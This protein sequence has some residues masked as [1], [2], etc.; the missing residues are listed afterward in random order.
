MASKAKKEVAKPTEAKKTEKPAEKKAEAPKKVAKPEAKKPVAAKREFFSTYIESKR[1][2][3][4][5]D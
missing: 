5:L 3:G 4:F 1:D 2:S